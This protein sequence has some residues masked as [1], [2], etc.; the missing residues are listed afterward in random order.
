MEVRFLKEDDYDT[1]VKWWE[2]N[3]FP[4]PSRDM[5][6]ENGT[7]GIMVYKD[8]VEICAGFLYLTNSSM[9]WCEYIVANFHYR[10]DDRQEAILKVIDTIS[11]IAK[12]R[13]VRVMY[14]SLN[15]DSLI[16]SYKKCGYITGSGKCTE[17]VKKL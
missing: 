2:D 13:G 14:T 11:L 4:A 3:R 5:L 15:R 17:M 9:A 7:C 1:L 10:D 8:D 6:P 12:D 16:N